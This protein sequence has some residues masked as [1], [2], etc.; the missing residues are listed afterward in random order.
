M[1]DAPNFASILDEAPDEVVFPKPLPVGTYTFVVGPPRYD[2]SSKKQ[3][4]F[5]EFILQPIAAEDD[6]DEN[7]LLE[8]GGFDGKSIRAVYYITPDAIARLD[9]FHTHC[10]IDLEVPL[11]RRLRNDE[12]MN[13][14][15]LG[16]IRHNTS[17]NGRVYAELSK[18]APVE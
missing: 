6:V 17:D 1:V 3:T 10:G 7:D 12:C 4:D 8:A 5:V 2:K 11:S 18:T 9:E 14:S 15:V 13:T 16:T